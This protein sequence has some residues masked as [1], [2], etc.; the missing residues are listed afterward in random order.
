MEQIARLPPFFRNKNA[1]KVPERGVPRACNQLV[2]MRSAVRICPAAPEKLLKSLDFGSFCSVFLK[3]MW[4]RLWVNCSD[5]QPDPH[6]EMCG[7]I[8]RVPGRKFGL[9]AWC[10]S[11]LLG[12]VCRSHHLSH[13]AA[14]GFRR[15]IL[16]LTG[17]V[18][19]GA[20]GEACVVVAQHTGHRLDVHTVLKCKRGEGVT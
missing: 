13:E 7:K 18:G 14:H 1:P 5:P 10:F 11:M 20:E 8:Q 15:L 16:H 12:C 4:V 6:G 19:V 3:I 9:P 2:R 17:G